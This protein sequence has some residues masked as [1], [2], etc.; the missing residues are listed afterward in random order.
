MR[1]FISF[2]IKAKV[3][4]LVVNNSVQRGR[5]LPQRKHV[6]LKSL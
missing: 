1:L 2:D 6:S 4:L 3:L 5:L